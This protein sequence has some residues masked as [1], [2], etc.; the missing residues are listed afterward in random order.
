MLRAFH[1]TCIE[2]DGDPAALDGA[3]EI[4]G[5]LPE[6]AGPADLLIR[7]RAG[8]ARPRPPGPR[9]FYHGVVEAFVDGRDV[10]LWDGASQARVR[11]GGGEIAVEVAPESL[12]DGHVFAH[13]F[14]LVAL[15]V[16]L[17]WR[18]LFHVHAG[19]LVAPGGRGILV[20]GDAGAGKSTLSLALIE[21]GCDFLGD[22]A[23]FLRT[24]VEAEVLALPRAFHVAPRTAAAF[25]RVA[26]L[27]GE[28][29]PAGEKRR[30]DPFV[31]WPG[32]QRAT[33]DF[34]EVILLPT[35]EGG[36]ETTLERVNAA[37]ALG[38]LLESSTYAIVEGLPGA[39]DHL[40]AL[41]RVADG[42]RAYR[43]RLGLDLLEHPE[44]IAR[45]VLAST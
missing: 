19:A 42:A 31:A 9:A 36:M 2:V 8:P 45:R 39:M 3:A 32:R 14:L 28:C 30:L 41:R 34:P 17:R 22:D 29:L 12:R 26:A 33:M 6:G 24:A 25:P 40:E 7:L 5:G 1:G 13:V 37:E 16:A 23:V 15:V 11:A 18:D 38:A 35:V 44:E 20:V 4:L 27:L 10:I 21:A 43:V